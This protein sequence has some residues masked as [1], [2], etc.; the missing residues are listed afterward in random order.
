MKQKSHHHIKFVIPNESNYCLM[1]TKF[2]KYQ[3]NRLISFHQHAASWWTSDK[4][5]KDTIWRQE[6]QIITLNTPDIRRP[7]DV[8]TMVAD[9]L[10]PK[11]TLSRKFNC[12][13]A[14]LRSYCNHWINNLQENSGGRQPVGFFAIGGSSHRDNA[15]WGEMSSAI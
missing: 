7:D 9:V 8:F 15:P 11:T 13:I 12:N 5:K 6:A 3:V 1:I 4:R 2:Y 10:W 14:W